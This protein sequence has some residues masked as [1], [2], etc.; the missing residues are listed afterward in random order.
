[1]K[2][3]KPHLLGSELLGTANPYAVGGSH[4]HIP[5]I[6]QALLGAQPADQQTKDVRV[7]FTPVLV[8]M[9]RGILA[10]STAQIADGATDAQ[11][12]DAWESAYGA[13]TFVQLLPEGRF[14]RTAD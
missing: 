8:P 1:G 11:I 14:P 13:E 10:T 5:E 6:Q 2:S 3:L 9:A 4:R 12:R 7:S